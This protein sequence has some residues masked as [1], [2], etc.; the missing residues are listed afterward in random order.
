MKIGWTW[1]TKRAD[2][3]RRFPRSMLVVW[4]DHHIV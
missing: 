4:I 3:R 2:E 1:N